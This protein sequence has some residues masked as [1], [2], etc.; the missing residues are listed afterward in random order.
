MSKINAQHPIRLDSLTGVSQTLMIPLFCRAWEH[1]TA[2]SL[3]P[4]PM[5]ATI[6]S[7]L[8][9]LLEN[10][11]NPYHQSMLTRRWPALL[12]LIMSMR[13]RHFD[14]RCLDFIQRHPDA[15]VVMLGCGLDSRYERLNQPDIP[16]YNLDLP[17]V[18]NLRQ[19]LFPTYATVNDLAYSV[20]DFKWFE[21]IDQRRPTIF[22]AEGLF[23]YLARSQ[24]R[25]LF[26]H[27]AENF[28]GELIA[29][30][31]SQP[32]IQAVGN[33]ILQVTTRMESGTVFVGGLYHSREPEA[34]HPQIRF[35]DDWTFFDEREP[36]LGLHNL[37][38][39][40][41]YQRIQWVVRYQLES[42]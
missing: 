24:T 1:E 2:N 29:E 12:K 40:T 30:V 37:V 20:L 28:T 10:S 23:M 4:D 9:V 17:H 11:D 14:R 19:Q 15:Q 35:V 22:L 8:N 33:K 6:V 26:K 34:W 38:R 27:L 13:A 18:M 25:H 36:R 16:W 3:L 31:M 39:F 5:A 32:A 7:Q 42:L 41:P 21:H